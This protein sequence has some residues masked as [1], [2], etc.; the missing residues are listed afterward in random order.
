[1]KRNRFHAAS[2]QAT[3]ELVLAIP[4]MILLAVVAY[5]CL[6]FFSEASQFDRSFRNAVRVYA[7]S[8]SSSQSTSSTL[9]E[10]CSEVTRSLG[11]N[12]QLSVHAEAHNAAGGLT[13]FTGTLIYRPT[14]FGQ[15]L[16]S[17]LFG[18]YLSAVT[19]TTTLTVSTF[20]AGV[21]I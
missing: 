14:L 8:P 17:R 1:M 21:F 18:Y 19:H 11:N 10:I 13:S 3:I 16:R 2:G 15:P 6:V 5:N 7:V 9:G 12:T 4:A 20:K